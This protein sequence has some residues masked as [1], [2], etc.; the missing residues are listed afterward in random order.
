MKSHHL[1]RDRGARAC[2]W[3][4]LLLLPLLAVSC[5]RVKSVLLANQP[6][7]VSITNG[8]IDTSTV[9]ST[10]V[11]EMTWQGDDLDGD[12][13]R[14]EYS[15]DP[16]TLH[17]A[18]F[19]AVETTWVST[20]QFGAQI[21]FRAARR[22]GSEPGSTA[23]EFHTFVIRAI[24]DGG[25]ASPVV[26]RAFYAR[27][28]APD[29]QISSPVPSGLITWGLPLPFRVRWE[30]DDAD[31]IG[32]QRPVGFRVRLVDLDLEHVVYLGDPDSLVREGMANDWV[33]WRFVAGDTSELV[34][35]EQDGLAA[36]RSGLL[37]IL[38]VDQAG[39]TTPYAS[40]YKNVLQFTSTFAASGGP[41][42]RIQ[43]PYVDF[44]YQSGG[45]VDDPLY[46]IPIEAPAGRAIPFRWE[47]SPAPGRQ[48]AFS[49]WLL[50]GLSSTLETRQDPGDLAHWSPFGPAFDEVVLPPLAA[51]VHRFYVEMRDDLGGRSLAI[52]VI[53]CVDVLPSRELL[54][55]DDTRLEGDRFS[56]GRTLPYSSAWPSA[57]ELDTFLFARGG[58]PWRQVT[59]GVNV[60]S[61]PGLFAGYAFDTLGTRRG[62]ENAA[63][64]VTLAQL[65]QYRHVLW[66][67][68]GRGAQYTDDL[69]QTLFPA[70][71]LYA[72]SAPGRVGVLAPYVAAGGKVWLAGGGAA[73]ASLKNFDRRDN[74]DGAST[75]FEASTGE[76][77]VGRPLFDDAHLRSRVVTVRA[78]AVPT[79][80]PAARG[81]WSGHGP[82]RDLNA[83]DYARLPALN[84]RAAASDPLP[85]TRLTNQSGLYYP[86]ATDVEYVGAP[87]EIT[88]PIGGSGENQSTLD[89]LYEHSGAGLLV[90][91]APSMLYYHG[92]DN[93][94]FVFTGFDLWS[95]SHAE[96]QALVDFVLQDIWGLAR[97]P[98]V[99]SAR[100]AG[101]TRTAPPR[102]VGVAPKRA[103]LHT[104]APPRRLDPPRNRP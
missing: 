61:P 17:Q 64:A 72:M 52:I 60:T 97:G 86:I 33:G 99:A 46:E 31:G 24:D 53:S 8:P 95:W 67:V 20:T 96:S 81:G 69:D 73:Y 47:G 41:R 89:T 23:S 56:A 28:V 29:V 75:V 27:T 19:A 92:R 48:V 93:A 90:S 84:F 85:P 100:H 101:I 79:R 88:E 2:A 51:G 59:T 5:D 102:L 3:A 10:W 58:F 94:P 35:G 82:A 4:W 9:V 36:G 14:F 49:R 66:L 70:T 50:D 62:F 16:P 15:I 83:P 98:V 87:N 74:N 78:N 54:V 32:T 43:S 57:A 104:V 42:I 38:A 71:S 63:S 7:T 39:A 30:G 34:L 65:G 11:V 40:L 37:A 26:S 55:I 68:D 80:S 21:R 6:P 77:A 12:V 45:F 25:A 22:D 18:R 103:A 13:V 76:L 44:A 1:D 91:P